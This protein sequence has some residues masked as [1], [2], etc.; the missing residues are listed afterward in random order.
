MIRI[1]VIGDYNSKFATHV[2][3]NTAVEHTAAGLDL[4]LRAEWVPTPELTPASTHN[5]LSKYDAVWA[6]PGSPYKSGEGMLRGIEYARAY[7]V[8]F[9]AT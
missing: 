3:I 8:P 4:D 6:S 9:T 1:A 2:A 7:N 5:L